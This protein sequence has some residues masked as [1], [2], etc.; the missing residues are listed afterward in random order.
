MFQLERFRNRVIQV[1]FSTPGIKAP[2]SEISD[3]E[4]LDQLKK[5]IDE[6]T[7]FYRQV[8]DLKEQLKLADTNS[9]EF[10]Q[11]MSKLRT[12]MEQI[13]VGLILRLSLEGSIHSHHQNTQLSHNRLIYLTNNGLECY[14]LS[15][16]PDE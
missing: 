11:N 13:V 10:K 9:A 6:R 7:E 5:I 14:Y 16:I 8:K 12:D 3:D 4:L 1:T 15:K 2:E